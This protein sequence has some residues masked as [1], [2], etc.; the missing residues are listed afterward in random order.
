MKTIFGIPDMLVVMGDTGV[1]K[2]PAR[3]RNAPP[4][5]IK[6]AVERN[7]RHQDR[8]VEAQRLGEYSRQENVSCQLLV[9][10][11]L[12]GFP[13]TKIV[14]VSSQSLMEGGVLKSMNNGHHGARDCVGQRTAITVNFNFGPARHATQ[15]RTTYPQA[16]PTFIDAMASS[17]KNGWNAS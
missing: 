8:H 7:H 4:A 5:Q 16:T 11:I 17:S 3:S 9:V 14:Q 12:E 13:V 10:Y 15:Q 6:L 1:Y 2:S